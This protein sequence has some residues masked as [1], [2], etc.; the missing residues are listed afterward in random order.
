MSPDAATPTPAETRDWTFVVRGRCPECGFDPDELRPSAVPGR[1]LA[2]VASW[3]AVLDSSGP[4]G[5]GPDGSGPAGP[6]RR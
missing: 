2:T 6:G 3:S 5:S 1:I 4:D